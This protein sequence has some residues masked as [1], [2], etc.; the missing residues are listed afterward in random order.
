VGGEV[1]VVVGVG[2]A[3]MLHELRKI[4]AIRIPL[5]IDIL[6]GETWTRVRKMA[7]VFLRNDWSM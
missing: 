5:R 3:V 4:P 7:A 6:R 1:G 2:W